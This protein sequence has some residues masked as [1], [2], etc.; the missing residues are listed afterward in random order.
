MEATAN[1]INIVYPNPPQALIDFKAS[2]GD[3]NAIASIVSNNEALTKEV[4]ATINAPYFALVREIKNAEE[5]VRMLGVNRIVNLATGRLLRTTVFSG[6]RKALKD[7]WSTSLKAAV[8]GV[9]ISKDLDIGC[10]DEVY[11][12]SLFHNS[13]MA[14]LYQ[15]CDNYEGIIKGAYEQEDSDVSAFE[16]SKLDT[17]HASISAQLAQKWGMSGDIAKAIHAHHSPD[18]TV[19]LIESGGEAG[20]LLLILKLS[21]QIARIPGY[22]SQCPFNHE[23]EKIKE[24]ILD[25]LTLTEGM[26]KRFEL[27]IKKKLAALKS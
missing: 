8:I 18:K 15:G 6:E 14:L 1:S 26:Y 21:E 12:T 22:L 3:I 5:A 11:A 7:L 27:V 20:E 17:S 25:Q 23:W 19:K 24:P 9:L 4:L 13:G 10:T 16:E 2:K